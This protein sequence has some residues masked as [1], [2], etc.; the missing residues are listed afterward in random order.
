MKRGCE[1][2]ICE[3]VR[4]KLHCKGV[5]VFKIP[6]AGM[7]SIYCRQLWALKYKSKVMWATG[8]RTARM[9]RLRPAGAQLIP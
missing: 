4:I 2:P 5:S 9:G 6:D 1:L 3:V 7:R 8:C